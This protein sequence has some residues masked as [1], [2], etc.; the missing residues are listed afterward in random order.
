VGTAADIR[1]PV[2][3]AIPDLGET[4]VVRFDLEV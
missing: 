1:G 2:E 4:E 3:A